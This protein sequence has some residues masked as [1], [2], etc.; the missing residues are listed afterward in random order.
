MFA[1]LLVPSSR[2]RLPLY[3]LLLVLGVLLLYPL[4]TTPGA[5]AADA[6]PR[7]AGLVAGW[8]PA[9]RMCEMDAADFAS[10]LAWSCLRSADRSG[11]ELR[12]QPSAR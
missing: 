3:A 12:I 4:T 10:G 1:K 8:Y 9:E 7:P 5:R 6:A 2:S 11:W